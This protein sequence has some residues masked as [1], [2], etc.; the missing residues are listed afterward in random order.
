MN[1]F[2]TGGKK[3]SHDISPHIYRAR[4]V[5]SSARDKKNFE[6]KIRI[7]IAKEFPS[8]YR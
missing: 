4:S 3:M 5:C 7:Y 1:S 2:H 8:E 6:W